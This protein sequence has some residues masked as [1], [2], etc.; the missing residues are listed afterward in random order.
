M[1]WA[2]SRTRADGSRRRASHRSLRDTH[3]S[4]QYF[5]KLNT[6]LKGSVDKMQGLLATT[7]VNEEQ[8]LRQLA[9]LD[10]NIRRAKVVY[11]VREV[12]TAPK[13]DSATF[14]QVTRNKVVL[15]YLAEAGQAQNEKLVAELAKGRQERTQLVSDLGTLNKLVSDAI[16]SNEVLNSHLNK[17]ATGQL[18]D[19]LAEVGRQITAF[20]GGLKAADQNNPAI[21]QFV[22]AGNAADKRVQQADEGLSKFIDVWFKLNQKAK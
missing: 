16:A 11:S 20:N 9:L 18:T 10:D 12:L 1:I 22:Q 7:A 3:S 21:R 17:S 14:T 8:A 13:G 4:S 19:F 2:S 6:Q 5:G 15:Y